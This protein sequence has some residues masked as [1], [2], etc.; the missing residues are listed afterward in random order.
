MDE[1]GLCNPSRHTHIKKKRMEN[2]KRK[3]NN[4]I[5]KRVK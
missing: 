5:Y 4:E 3:S 2:E 1:N